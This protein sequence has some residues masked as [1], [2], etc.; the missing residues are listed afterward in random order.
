MLRG[1]REYMCQSV[2]HHIIDTVLCMGKQFA[3]EEVSQHNKDGDLV[4]PFL[5]SLSYNV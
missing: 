3:V 4:C 2:N 1:Q 5:S